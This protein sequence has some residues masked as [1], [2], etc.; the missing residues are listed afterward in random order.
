[1]NNSKSILNKRV[2]VLIRLL[3]CGESSKTEV[4]HNALGSRKAG[5]DEMRIAGA[6]T[7]R[8]IK[9]KCWEHDSRWLPLFILYLLQFL[10]NRRR[11]FLQIFWL[12]LYLLQIFLL[13]YRLRMNVSFVALQDIITNGGKFNNL[14]RE[15]YKYGDK[16]RK[17]EISSKS[18]QI[19]LLLSTSDQR[20][21]KIVKLISE[22]EF[23]ER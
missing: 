1:M 17:I 5:E 19:G 9:A 12:G 16:T 7:R 22:Q 18:Q 20:I 13:T 11:R 14:L 4:N 8:D 21:T 23:C 15:V 6:C 2:V 10:L 3:D